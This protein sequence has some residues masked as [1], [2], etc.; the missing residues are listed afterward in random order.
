MRAGVNPLAL[1]LL[2]CPVCRS[3]TPDLTAAA[4]ALTCSRGHRFPIRN[5]IPDFT[6]D[7]PVVK[8]SPVYDVMWEMHEQRAYPEIGVPTYAQK[9]QR[10]AQLPGTLDAYVRDRLVLDAGCGEGRFTYL[11]SALGARHVIAADYSL[12][13][14]ERARQ[15]TGNPANVTFIRANLLQP[16]FVP[17]SV[18]LAYSFGVVHHT[19]D[20]FRSYQ[21]VRA[22]LKVGGYL[23]IYVYKTGTLPLI[24]WPL[25]PFTTRMDLAT[26]R[27]VCVFFGWDYEELGTPTLPLGRWFRRLGRLDVLGIGRVNFEFLSTRYLR[28]HSR[29]EVVRWFEESGMEVI[30]STEFVSVSGRRV[31]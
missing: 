16:P 2:R 3:S 22:A 24:V 9:F 21:A 26:I 20:S 29:R 27:R 6:G 1:S 7:D 23:A 15:Q 13:A 11:A 18:D 12:Y 10:F 14:L 30:A 31:A 25:R 19:P 4:D 8:D 5:G 28:E 17:D